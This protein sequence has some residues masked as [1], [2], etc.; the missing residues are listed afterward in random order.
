M[1]GN[2]RSGT[3]VTRLVGF[4][5][6]VLVWVISTGVTLEVPGGVGR[7][8][9]HKVSRVSGEGPGSQSPSVTT[10]E[11]GTPDCRVSKFR[12]RLRRIDTLRPVQ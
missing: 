4:G 5:E 7:G 12:S 11:S 6:V 8:L 2:P 1:S 10:L 9:R 3:S